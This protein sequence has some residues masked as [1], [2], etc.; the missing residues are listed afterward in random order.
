[1][2]YDLVQYVCTYSEGADDDVV[3][4]HVIGSMEIL[5]TQLCVC[6]NDAHYRCV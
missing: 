4:L 2:T 3:A 6:L 5:F 1:M